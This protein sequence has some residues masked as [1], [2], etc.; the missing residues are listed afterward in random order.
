MITYRNALDE[1]RRQALDR[2]GVHGGVTVVLVG[3]LNVLWTRL[4]AARA[5]VVTW[6]TDAAE[7]LPEGV[8]WGTL[9]VGV[10]V[11]ALAT[12]AVVLLRTRPRPLP[13]D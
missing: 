7:R 3:L 11:A 6:V 5:Q 2:G 4:S 13:A 10:A 9:L 12:G 8:P 1:L